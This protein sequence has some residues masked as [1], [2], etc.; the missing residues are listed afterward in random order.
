MKYLLPAVFFLSGCSASFGGATYTRSD[1][2]EAEAAYYQLQREIA[3]RPLVEIIAQP[4]Q[5]ITGL[6]S[7]RV[8]SP[9]STAQYRQEIHPAWSLIG[10]VANTVLPIV[11]TSWGAYKLVEAIG[12]TLRD[13]VVVNQPP[14]VI[15][16]P[17][18]TV[19]VPQ[20]PPI[21]V[22]QPAPIIVHPEVIRVDQ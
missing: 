22:T 20:P 16:P 17:S 11:G 8:Y 14:P 7:I 4:D 2:L 10:Q 13:P 1:R 3:S 5:Q 21:I 9:Q 15:V 12:G 6:A 19:V 18:D